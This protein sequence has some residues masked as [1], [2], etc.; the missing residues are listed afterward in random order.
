M[1]QNLSETLHLMSCDF[2]LNYNK[3]NGT[4]NLR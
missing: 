2:S 4:K 3:K 1:L